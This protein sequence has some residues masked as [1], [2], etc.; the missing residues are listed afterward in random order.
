[1]QWVRYLIGSMVGG[2]AVWSIW[3]LHAGRYWES[4]GMLLSGVAVYALY[5]FFF[6]RYVRQEAL[7]NR[8]EKDGL[9]VKASIV[10]VHATSTYINEVPVM[11]IKLKY[12]T[13][14][15]EHVKEI[16]QPIPYHALSYLQAGKRISILVD[17][18]NTEQFVLPF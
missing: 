13:Q 7:M 14:G 5:Y 12:V 3:S 2:Y 11:R 10:G 4:A 15:K 1:M 16:K 6:Q 17:P 8:L 9:R 18:K